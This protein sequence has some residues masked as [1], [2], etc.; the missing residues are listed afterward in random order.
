[1]DASLDQNTTTTVTKQTAATQLATN[2]V[3]NGIGVSK[4]VAG[5]QSEQA[6]SILSMEAMKYSANTIAEVSYQYE[7]YTRK[8]WDRDKCVAKHFML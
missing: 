1:M 4:S 5:H 7:H 6:D 8:L 2:N 3:E